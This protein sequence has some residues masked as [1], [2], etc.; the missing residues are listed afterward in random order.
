VTV[1]KK[2]RQIV[3][4]GAVIRDDSDPSKQVPVANASIIA[5]TAG[6]TT[7]ARSD[8]TGSFAVALPSGFRGQQPV[9]LRFEHPDYQ[10]L[11]LNEF[12]GDKLYVARM[13]PVVEPASGSAAKQ[14]EQ[15][16]SNIRVRY[17][18]RTMSAAK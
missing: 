3:L 8:Q 7:H 16:I 4:R 18:F 12:T 14:P 9:T 10:P 17:V 11:Q 2:H 13:I 15:V 6:L 5:I 1:V